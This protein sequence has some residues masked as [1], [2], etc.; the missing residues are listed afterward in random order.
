MSEAVCKF[1]ITPQVRS[2]QKLLNGMSLEVAPD[3]GNVV[4]LNEESEDR[5]NVNLVGKKAIQCA[6]I[7][8]TPGRQAVLELCYGI[9]IGAASTLRPEYKSEILDRMIKVSF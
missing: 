3:R 5:Q 1:W 8:S 6:H 9:G 7:R 4:E 2:G